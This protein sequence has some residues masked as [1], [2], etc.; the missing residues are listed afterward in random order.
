ME[1]GMDG[2]RVDKRKG[3]EPKVA[4]PRLF[5]QGPQES[6]PSLGANQVG[7]EI[8][9]SSNQGLWNTSVDIGIKIRSYVMCKS[10][11]NIRSVQ[12]AIWTMTM[13]NG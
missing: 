2:G 7:S 8:I 12:P 5:A 9:T 10:S 13:F 11:D 4:E 3:K 1:G 6:L